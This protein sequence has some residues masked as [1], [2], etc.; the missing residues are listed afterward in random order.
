MIKLSDSEWLVM[1]Q[2]WER[3]QTIT[4][5]TASLREST[6]WTKHTI[7]TFL[8]RMLEKGAIRFE[9]GPRAKRY[10][11]LVDRQEA[12]LEEANQFLNRCFSGRIGLMVNTMLSGSSLTR[13][14]IDEL[15]DILKQAEVEHDD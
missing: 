15:Y 4:E 8:R 3:P 7:L 14:E 6:G 2:L 13:A 1:N 9:Q 12:R 5:L 10:Y 11:P